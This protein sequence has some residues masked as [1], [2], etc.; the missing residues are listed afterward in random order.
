M[1]KREQKA[2]TVAVPEKKAPGKKIILFSD[3]TGNSAAALFKTNVRRVYEALDLSCPEQIA[4]YDDGVGSSSFKPWAAISGATGFGLARNVRALYTFLSRNY[5]PGDEIFVFGFSRGSFTARILIGLI[6]SQGIIPRTRYQ[7]DAE[8]NQLVK[9]AYRNYRRKYDMLFGLVRITRQIRDHLVRG[10]H[11]TSQADSIDLR[12]GNLP[13]YDPELAPAGVTVRFLGLWDTVDA[14]GLPIDE[15]TLGWSEWVWPLLMRDQKLWKGVQKACHALALDDER[16]TFHP[17]LIDET[18]EP[19]GATN[20]S[21]ERISQ[22][23][24]TGMHAD[25]GGGYPNDGLSYVTLD[26]MLDQATAAGLIL[27]PGVK[28]E[29]S[30][31]AD[32]LGHLNNSRKGLGGY[33][34]YQPRKIEL[35]PGSQKITNN[36][37]KIHQ[38]VFDRIKH[39][40]GSYSPI[41]LPGSYSVVD[42]M[43]NVS[44]PNGTTYGVETVARAR[45][46]AN[47]QERVWNFVWGRRVTYF[48]T[49]F[50]SALLAA[51]P[52]L[53]PAVVS[54]STIGLVSINDEAKC[55]G[56]SLCFLAGLPDL[57]GGLLPG[58]L[59]TWTDAFKSNPGVFAALA[60][61][62][63]LFTY[64]GST[65]EVTI[66]DRMALIWQQ[67][68][69]APAP[70][71]TFIQRL[72]QNAI[73]RAFFRSMKYLILPTI[74]GITMA[75]VLYLYVPYIAA[76]RIA[77]AIRDA[78][79]DYCQ[80]KQMRLILPGGAATAE[81]VFDTKDVCWSTG[82]SLLD[83]A[84]Y[85]VSLTEIEPWTDNGVP[86]HPEGLI[87]DPRGHS[88]EMSAFARLLG[89]ASKRVVSDDYMVPIARIASANRTTNV[90]QDEY[91]LRPVIPVNEGATNR[92]FK[93]RFTASSSGELFL[94]VNDSVLL[95]PWEFYSNNEG[96]SKVSVRR[97]VTCTESVEQF[98]SIANVADEPT[99]TD[100]AFVCQ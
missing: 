52:W 38:S 4:Y 95:W 3:G 94:Y 86:A 30:S 82:L 45:D 35:L 80:Q 79:G 88:K 25:V 2:K 11:R 16:N 23:W 12:V 7:G 33:Y 19:A 56:S 92:H 99:G 54:D 42:S 49:L 32:P 39:F 22:V 15:L 75:A 67:S 6:E 98:G 37:I 91:V 43:G 46:R 41:G 50:F 17:R 47:V 20:I 73:Y 96:K 87:N 40:G 61:L 76:N 74:F 72:R 63:W 70:K 69:S 85:E 44:P 26:W 97:V 64:L 27:R 60:F 62:I 65:L 9:W 55:I 81:G 21:E 57:L 28:V 77:F 59:K 83:G 1:A 89:W 14:Y 71:R 13:P 18:K 29:I 90:G 58:F 48:V 78:R 24:F 66:K 10:W 53:K 100:P 5:V 36:G 68:P 93:S 31:R 51:L 8:L 34:R 84:T